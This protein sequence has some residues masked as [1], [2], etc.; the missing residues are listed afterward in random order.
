VK[1][2]PAKREPSLYEYESF[3]KETDSVSHSS[4]EK[5]IV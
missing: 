1:A 3:I 4:M 5:L 2:R